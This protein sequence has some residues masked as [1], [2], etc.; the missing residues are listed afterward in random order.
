MRRSRKARRF[1]SAEKFCENAH[2]FW[3]ADNGQ[4]T[5]SHVVIF[6]FVVVVDR[7]SLL[8]V[9]DFLFFNHL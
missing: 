6:L 5:C 7:V 9:L 3:V 1:L 2:D 8:L 4:I